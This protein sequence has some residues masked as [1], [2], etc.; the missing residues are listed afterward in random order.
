MVVNV[1]VGAACDY[2]RQ[3]S[4]LGVI[5]DLDNTMQPIEE[6]NEF[7]RNASKSAIRSFAL[8]NFSGPVVS[9]GYLK[10]YQSVAAE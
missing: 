8:A 7:I 10:C 6:V 5:L 1:N 9:A 3:N 2:I 4:Y